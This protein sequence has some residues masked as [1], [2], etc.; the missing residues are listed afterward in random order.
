MDAEALAGDHAPRAG[1]PENPATVTARVWCE[2]GPPPDPRVFCESGLALAG[3]VAGRHDHGRARLDDRGGII[4][5]IG[6]AS[7]L[8]AATGFTMTEVGTL[9]LGGLWGH[10]ATIFVFV[11]D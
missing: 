10:E 9:S 6:S 1:E 8:L 4:R 5:R 11:D 7:T 3:R 2:A